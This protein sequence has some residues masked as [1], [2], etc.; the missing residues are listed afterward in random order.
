MTTAGPA[1]TPDGLSKV[2]RIKRTSAQLRGTIAQELAQETD[3]FSETSV[4]LNKFHGIYQQDDR[5]R[6]QAARASGQAKAYSMMIRVRIPGGV[7]SPDAYLAHD[8]LAREYGNGTLRVTTRQDFQLHGVLKGDLRPAIRAIN[9]TLLTTLGGCGDVERNIMICPAPAQDRL[10]QEVTAV[11]AKLVP[12]L[13]PSA[14]AYHEIWLDGELASSSAL[15]A[16][17]L[18]GDSYLPRKFKTAVALEGD[19]C[20]DVYANDLG[21]VAVPTDDRG[22][23]GFV[24]LVGG[25][26]GRTHNRPETFAA[27]ATPI[28]LTSPDRV[29]EVCRA[30]IMVQRDHG[31]RSNR[32]QA[33]LKYLIAARGLDWF[34]D[35]VETRVGFQ[36]APAPALA[37]PAIDDHLGWHQQGD[38][39]AFL[40]LHID[41]G[42]IED[43]DQGHLG[44]A[45]RRLVATLRPGVRLTPQQNLI[46]TGIETH[47]RAEVD[48]LLADH[49][50]ALA[51]E[52]HSARRNAMACPALPTC[53]LAL[54]EAERAMPELVGRLSRLMDELDLGRE[55][56]SYRMTG[57]PNGCTRPYLGDVGLVGTTLGKYDLLLGG[58]SSGTRLNWAYAQN[59]PFI[60]IV[61]VL[62][63][64][65][66]LYAAARRPGERFGEW[67]HEVGPE[68]L[69]ALVAADAN[70]V[71]RSQDG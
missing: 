46:L 25:G 11:L 42:R 44:T 36:F 24:V 29:L 57:C 49:G 50:V 64:P 21:L 45:L 28:G 60:E 58:D 23:A 35:E 7:V 48:Q 68:R 52:L 65:L 40:G 32:R 12:A 3:Q 26:M 14:G 63:G 10:R 55:Q 67:C 43:S 56:I 20:V 18:Y 33:R 6:R 38:R 53:G 22:L 66:R 70:H 31:D 8:Q 51:E 9:A 19:N 5:D 17:P 54:A 15:A 37:W 59:V 39:S 69:A 13:A 61:E 62:R 1:P 2:E 41:N 4:Q 27:L 30:V 16:D 47:R 34:R 71:T